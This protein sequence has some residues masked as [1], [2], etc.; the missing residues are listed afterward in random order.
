MDSPKL[1]AVVGLGGALLSADSRYWAPAL[2]S[3][4]QTH[5][6]CFTRG[7]AR[8]GRRDGTDRWTHCG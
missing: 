6:E 5:S 1:I 4:W 3:D 7:L 2:P 8:H